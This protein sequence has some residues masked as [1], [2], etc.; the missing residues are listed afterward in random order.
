MGHFVG[1]LQLALVLFVQKE[2]VFGQIFDLDFQ[3]FYLMQKHSLILFLGSIQREGFRL[4]LF[5]VF[6]TL[7]QE[8]HLF[9][10]LF[11]KGILFVHHGLQLLDFFGQLVGLFILM[12]TFG[13][14]FLEESF[15]FLQVIFEFAH[16][17]L[18]LVVVLVESL[19]ITLTVHEL[20]LKQVDLL[21]GVSQLR[22]QQLHLGPQLG[23]YLQI[24]FVFPLL[25][26]FGLLSV[27]FPHSLL[28][29]ELLVLL[30]I[31]LQFSVLRHQVLHSG[32]ELPHLKLL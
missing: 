3:L 20:L 7:L 31:L 12:V 29:Q 28:D 10:P 27:L 25:M 32:L 21:F 6:F 15:F 26:L 13:E 22:G 24:L 16:F 30:P 17:P 9:V 11:Q 2:V 18:H 14:L 19:L 4:F 5:Q 8:E 1:L 23:D